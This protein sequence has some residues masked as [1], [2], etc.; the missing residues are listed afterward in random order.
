MV[1]MDLARFLRKLEIKVLI[2][3]LRWLTNYQ[4]FQDFFL[5]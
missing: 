4:I 1:T 3:G 2:K 5:G